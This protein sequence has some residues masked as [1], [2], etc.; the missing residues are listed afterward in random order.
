MVAPFPGVTLKAG[1]RGPVVFAMQR[2][3]KRA[4]Y[5]WNRATGRYGA[6]TVRQVNAF[7][8]ASG[9]SQT[10]TYTKEV[11][12]KLA[13]WYDKYG[14]WLLT[15]GSAQAKEDAIR[16]VIEATALF[17]YNYRFNIPYAQERPMEGVLAHVKPPNYPKRMD[18]SETA[19]MCYYVA[20]APDPNGQGYNGWGNTWFQESHGHAVKYPGEKGD[21]VLYNGHVSIRV[22]TGEL[23]V[24]MGSYPMRL[25]PADYRTDIRSVRSYF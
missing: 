13:K 2:A 20:G 25:L 11:H 7:R 21:L 5:R 19:T 18:C 24:S 9:L 10:G 22:G 3:L 14:V 6:L 17:Y 1:A 16:N 12:S 4:G 15:H 23:V 8:K